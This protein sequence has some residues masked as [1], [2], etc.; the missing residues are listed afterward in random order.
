MPPDMLLRPPGKKESSVSKRSSSTQNSIAEGELSVDD[1]L[2]GEGQIKKKSS[3]KK[4]INIIS[5]ILKTKPG[6]ILK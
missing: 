5:N 4:K 3:S 1:I 6:V 2:L